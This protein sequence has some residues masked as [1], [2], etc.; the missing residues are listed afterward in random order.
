MACCEPVGAPKEAQR[1]EP[2]YG[3]V[4]LPNA[5]KADVAA[6][7][8]IARGTSRQ[9]LIPIQQGPGTERDD[10]HLNARVERQHLERVAPL[11][12]GR[13]RMIEEV[14]E[15]TAPYPRHLVRKPTARKP[16][17]AGPERLLAGE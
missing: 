10:G 16:E 14:V 4:P 12:P 2:T 3:S 5:G 11:D 13:H 7:R 6:S 17:N 8:N 1:I 15:A 9:G